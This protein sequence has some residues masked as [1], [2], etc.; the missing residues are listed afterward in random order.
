VQ[1]NLKNQSKFV[2]TPNLIFLCD[3]KPLAKFWNPMNP[4]WEKSNPSR[5][6]KEREKMP[7]IYFRDSTRKLLGPIKFVDAQ[8]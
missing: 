5:E 8:N 3:L 6:K 1:K 4:F 2:F 7:L